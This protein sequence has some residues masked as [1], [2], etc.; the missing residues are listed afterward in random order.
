[1]NSSRILSSKVSAMHIC[2]SDKCPVRTSS[3]RPNI[4]FIQV[5]STIYSQF[6]SQKSE[7]QTTPWE[8]NPY[9]QQNCLQ[10]S[11]SHCFSQGCRHHTHLSSSRGT[12]AGRTIRRLE[13][14]REI[15]AIPPPPPVY[16]LT[17]LTQ[18]IQQYSLFFK[19]MLIKTAISSL[20]P[21]PTQVPAHFNYTVT[22]VD[23]SK[24]LNVDAPSLKVFKVKL[25]GAL[26]NL[27]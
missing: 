18:Y 5:C 4:F 12:Q 11:S 22:K 10:R 13:T 2:T 24:H 16:N 15:S 7:S 26:S 6:W 14:G 20:L 8:I 23:M 27:V 17:Q 25:K 21:L 9:K 1:M 3:E 19:N